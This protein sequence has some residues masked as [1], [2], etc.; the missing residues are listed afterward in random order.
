M[1]LSRRPGHR[2]HPRDG[3]PPPNEHSED[4]V[5]HRSRKLPISSRRLPKVIAL[6]VVFLI[7]FLVG[8]SMRLKANLTIL[9]PKGKLRGTT[10]QETNATS[11]PPLPQ[12]LQ[13]LKTLPLETMTK[14]EMEYQ[15]QNHMDQNEFGTT[16]NK[17]LTCRQHNVHFCRGVV[18]VYRSKAMY[19]QVKRCL[20]ML[21]DAG[22]T[23]RILFADDET[24]TMVEEDMGEVTLMNSPVPW[25][26]KDQM[27]RIQCI[28]QKHSMIHR[29]FN[30]RNFIA[31]QATGKINIIDFGDA[32]VWQGGLWNP[33]NYNWRNLQ[34]MFSLWWRRH[35][36]EDQ[37]RIM[38]EVAEP[39]LVGKRI[40]R[41]PVQQQQAQAQAPK[42]NEA[43]GKQDEE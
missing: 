32:V 21:E 23:S 22:I 31:N 33:K 2:R 34:N 27:H 39:M 20:H 4:D 14:E 8:L 19:F 35:D 11:C 37:L 13:N 43:K 12:R 3:S 18:K 38:F 17:I 10:Q 28:L 42:E 7:Y 15:I 1:V 24:G 30:F 25:D 26:Y 40:W 5:P 9:P 36:S 29:D 6:T 16:G 41:Q